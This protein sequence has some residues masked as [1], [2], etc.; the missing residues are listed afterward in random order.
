MRPIGFTLLELLVVI[1][2]I[3]IFA[4]IG[5]S[6]YVKSTRKTEADALA[7]QVG[8][9]FTRAKARVRTSN[10][11]VSVT[12]NTAAKSITVAQ[13]GVTLSSITLNVSDM[14]LDCRVTCA[15]G[16]IGVIAPYAKLSTDVKISFTYAGNIRD[17]YIIGPTALLKV[18]KR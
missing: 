12:V 5:T 15:G 18:V 10:K 9:M 7:A 1:A 14:S 8:G 2:I 13:G 11:D 6:S 17:A 16:T 3:G 4:S